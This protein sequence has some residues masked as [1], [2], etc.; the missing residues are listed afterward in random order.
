[1]TLQV[2]KKY[3][4]YLYYLT[5]CFI[6]LDFSEDPMPT[7][8]IS[9]TVEHNET[10]IKPQKDATIFKLVQQPN[11]KQRKSYHKENRYILPVSNFNTLNTLLKHLDFC[12]LIYS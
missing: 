11:E 1:L 4:N 9:S 3:L 8:T 5:Y 12:K 10:I 2:I 7:Q 6:S